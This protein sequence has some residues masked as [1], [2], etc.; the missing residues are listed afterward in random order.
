MFQ[1]YM[2]LPTIVTF[3]NDKFEDLVLISKSVQTLE[4]N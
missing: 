4:N 3:W 1:L 2:I